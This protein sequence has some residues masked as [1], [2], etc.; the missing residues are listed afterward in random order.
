M[1][2]IEQIRLDFRME[3][4]AFARELYGRWNDFFRTSVEKV[5][6][7]TLSVYDRPEEVIRIESLCIDLG[8]IPEPEFYEHFPRKLAGKLNEVISDCLKYGGKYP[9]E[10]ISL[11]QNRLEVFIYFLQYGTW[12]SGYT[13]LNSGPAELFRTIIRTDGNLLIRWLKQ[14]GNTV[15]VR[16]RLAYQLQDEELEML[17]ELTE[18]SDADFIK[19]YVRYLIVAHHRLD[20]PEITA[21]DYRNVVWQVVFSY[22]LFESRSFFSRKQ[23]V[24]QTIRNL[25]THFNLIFSYLLH[26]LTLGLEKFSGEWIFIPELLTILTDIT[27]EQQASVPEVGMA[28]DWITGKS[29]F[30][31]EQHKALCRLLSEETSC[32]RLLSS[33]K[34]EEIIRLVEIIVPGESPFVISYAV[35]LEQE[36][37]RGM[38][39]GKA[40]SEFRLLKWEFLFLVLLSV[41]LTAFQRSRFVLTVIR[42][43]AAH[44]N[45]EEEILWTYLYAD[46]DNLPLPLAGV[47]REIRQLLLDRWR[48]DTGQGYPE[49]TCP[50][51]ERER[52]CLLLRHPL[53]ARQFLADMPEKK[54]YGWVNIVIPGESSFII[55]YAQ[56]LDR[57]KDRGMLEGKA[58]SGFRLLKWE[59]IFGVV[60]CA[61][62]SAF[63]RKRFVRE[64]LAQIGAHY[65]LSAVFLLNYFYR[66]VSSEEIA[67]SVELSSILR[68]LWEEDKLGNG[69]EI[70]GELQFRETLCILASRQEIP[71]QVWERLGSEFAIRLFSCWKETEVQGIILKYKEKLRDML[72]RSKDSVVSLYNR[73]CRTGGMLDFLVELYGRKQ[74]IDVFDRTGIEILKLT[75]KGSDNGKLCFMEGDVTEMIWWLENEAQYIRR[76]WE[77][78]SGEEIRTILG[79][80]SADKELTDRWIRCMGSVALRQAVIEFMELKK[81]VPAS[82]NEYFRVE[83]LLMYTAKAYSNF[84]SSEILTGVWKEIKKQLSDE[85]QKSLIMELKMNNLKL[86]R[87]KFITSPDEVSWEP[88]NSVMPEIRVEIDNAG[89]VLCSPY[90]PR[91]FSVLKYQDGNEFVSK[92]ARVKAAFILQHLLCD[93]DEYTELDLVLNKLLVGFS[94]ANTLPSQLKFENWELETIHSLLRGIMN[95]WDKMRNTSEEGFRYSFLNRKGIL[96]D[97]GET[98][99]LKVEEKAF[100]ILLDSLPWNFRIIKFP[101]MEKPITVKWR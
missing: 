1:I 40:G 100:D 70:T 3:K 62:V 69:D 37:E 65:N 29:I 50:P 30:T 4:E 26:I 68:E 71:E 54:I 51:S 43:I 11:Q 23:M 79:R 28:M 76:M 20:H 27:Q 84:S 55:F 34:E 91:L 8:N 95:N 52:L 57:E 31:E 88:D 89:L 98:W 66:M 81:I 99:E 25:A 9:V 82:L 13:N 97:K 67:V 94:L 60:L 46:L 86:D 48:Q 5:M 24:I 80:I 45:I 93:K 39:E 10:I 7:D 61:P 19:L 77:N 53:T 17:V 16:E 63:T 74:L 35:S 38:L 58:G 41:P 15:I 14:S 73:I 22:L 87:L 32:H 44:Y 21:T 92:E 6:D 83:D 2:A 90:F 33:L 47:L 56:T 72:F 75:P 49:K 59:F 42:Q 78:C 85:K 101:W 18:H 64:V 96:Q 12:P 36:K